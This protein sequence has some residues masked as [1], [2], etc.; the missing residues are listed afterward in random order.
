MYH[1]NV[2]W[3]NQTRTQISPRTLLLS[4][5]IAQAASAHSQVQLAL[6]CHFGLAISTSGVAF[7]FSHPLLLARAKVIVRSTK[8]AV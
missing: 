2:G 5:C 7:W 1:P 8:S 3:G 4:R 6:A